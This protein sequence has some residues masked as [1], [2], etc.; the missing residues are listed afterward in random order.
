MTAAEKADFDPAARRDLLHSAASA[1]SSVHEFASPSAL[2]S[3]PRC[4]CRH[5][6]EPVHA[7]WQA[8]S[9]RILRRRLW[10]F[11]CCKSSIHVSIRTP[12]GVLCLLA[13]F[14]TAAKAQQP[15]TEG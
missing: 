1:D 15:A 6:F 2:M 11:S 14:A 5:A 10:L 7:A 13:L 3:T 9:L 12:A 8:G 4:N